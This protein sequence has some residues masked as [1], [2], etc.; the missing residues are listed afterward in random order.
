MFWAQLSNFNI[1]NSCG[2]CEP[3]TYPVQLS[4]VTM[5]QLTDEQK[6]NIVNVYKR[7]CNISHTTRQCGCTRKCAK[8]WIERYSH[9]GGVRSSRTT[10]RKPALSEGAARLALELL[11]DGKQATA[12]A[13]ANELKVQGYTATVVD[14]NT[15]IRHARMA[16]AKAGQRLRA[17]R[18]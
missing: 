18:G 9:S 17:S 11:T 15:V 6:W 13:V 12:S 5:C 16:A 1:V 4:F 10:G 3:P 8:L 14:K 2:P 7:T